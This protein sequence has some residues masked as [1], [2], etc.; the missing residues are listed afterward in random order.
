VTKHAKLCKRA[1]DWS[2]E[3]LCY[4]IC[5]V[6]QAVITL[7]TKKTTGTKTGWWSAA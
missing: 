1:A 3:R 2:Q 5:N 4:G 6:I 7:K